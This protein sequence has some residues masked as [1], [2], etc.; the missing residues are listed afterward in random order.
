[1][2]TLGLV[3]PL[4]VRKRKEERY[5]TEL[6]VTFEGGG[7]GVIREV[8]ANGLYL[9]TDATLRRGQLVRFRLQFDNVSNGP[10]SVNCTARVMRVEKHGAKNGIAASFTR[11][12]FHRVVAPGRST[13]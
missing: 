1:M 4:F 8:S 6:V 2:L 10:I 5:S 12:E 13:L 9:V 11:F 3:R 7:N